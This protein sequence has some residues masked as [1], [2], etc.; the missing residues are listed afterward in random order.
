V[1]YVVVI[2]GINPG[3][4][5]VA[6]VNAPPPV[7]LQRAL[8]DQDDLQTVPGQV[9]V[10]VY[11]NAENLAVTAQRAH[12]PLPSGPIWSFPTAVDVQGWR[13]VLT[14]LAHRHGATGAIA[15]GTVYA[16]YAPAGDFTLEVGGHA[17]TR[18]PAFGWAGQYP[19][20]TAGPASLAFHN[21]PYVP[22]VVLVELAGWLVLAA[23]VLGWRPRRRA[24]Q[25]E[26]E[27]P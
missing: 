18:R 26:R 22:L 20:P 8:L 5:E 23:S 10:Q 7:D 3:S 21:F 14:P 12:P 25:P 17:A 9:G 6:S 1:R 27:E 4:S 13:P 24:A 11:Q 16:G 19:A 15:S 2:D